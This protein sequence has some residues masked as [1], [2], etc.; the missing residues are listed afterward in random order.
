MLGSFQSAYRPSSKPS[1]SFSFSSA[2]LWGKSLT[3]IHQRRMEKKKW[4]SEYGNENVLD[5]Y[6]SA[7]CK[8]VL[9]SSV[10]ER[11]E[12]GGRERKGMG[13]TVR[14]RWGKGGRRRGNQRRGGGERRMVGRRKQY[15]GTAA[16]YRFS[17]NPYLPKRVSGTFCNTTN[18]EKRT[19]FVSPYYESG[20]RWNTEWPMAVECITNQS[21]NDECDNCHPLRI[22]YF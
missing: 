8:F 17:E 18:Q 10:E 4:S 3:E 11:R 20:K 21:R 19:R 12:G 5:W 7:E 22:W 9:H 2:S 15:C 1:Q 6:D 14:L 13:M 16:K